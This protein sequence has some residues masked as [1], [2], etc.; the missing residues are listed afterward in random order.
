MSIYVKITV[1]VVSVAIL[2][3]AGFSFT[4]GEASAGE[5]LPGFAFIELFTSEGCS[6]CPPADELVSRIGKE[7]AGKPV[8]I[9]AYHVDYWDRLGWKDPFSSAQWS[10]R[11]RQ[12]SRWFHQNGV[13]TPQMV[14]NGKTEFVGSDESKLRKAIMSPGTPAS[15]PLN[16]QLKS[17][18]PGVAVINLTFP[19]VDGQELYLASV[20]KSA[21]VKV[22]RGENSGLTLPHTNIVRSLQQVAPGIGQV[23]L[24]L[25]KDFDPRNWEIIGFVQNTQTGE[26]L[27]AS[28]VNSAPRLN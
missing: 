1:L 17:L 2:A 14:V 21:T 24:V 22:T 20:Q 12:Y 9:L 15:T 4:G 18:S 11:Q 13:Y 25:P 28:T 26:I 16:L 10:E 8:Y 27:A 7:Y 3:I 6:S 19:K 23:S 5:P